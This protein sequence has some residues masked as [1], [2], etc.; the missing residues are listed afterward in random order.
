M[1]LALFAWNENSEGA[2]ELATAL[3]IRRIR[4]GP[5]SA[6]R[7]R[8]GKT[9]INWGSSTIPA[10]VEGSRILNNPARVAAMSIR[11]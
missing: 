7:G 4:R 3:G 5:E 10:N 11:R 1:A 8:A 6:Y 2:R 9:V